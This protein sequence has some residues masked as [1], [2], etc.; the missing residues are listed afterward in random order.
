M[1]RCGLYIG[2]E[3]NAAYSNAVA[4]RGT[5]DLLIRRMRVLREQ[6][7]GEELED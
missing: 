6:L 3:L 1:H 2:T 7:T 5:F 4:A